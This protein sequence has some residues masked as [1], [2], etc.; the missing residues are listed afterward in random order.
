MPNPERS[1]EI[2]TWTGYFASMFCSRTW[3]IQILST[4]L[5]G[6]EKIHRRTAPSPGRL[7]QGGRQLQGRPRFH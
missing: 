1:F 2:R 3:K 7:E 5:L 6:P 4:H